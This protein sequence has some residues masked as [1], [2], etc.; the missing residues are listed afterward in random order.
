MDDK[1]LL[2]NFFGIFRNRKRATNLDFVTLC[3]QPGASGLLRRAASAYETIDS[4]APPSNPLL[5]IIA[6]Q[7][8]V[9]VPTLSFISHVGHSQE[10]LI[11]YWMNSQ[12]GGATPD[13]LLAA[14]R[15]LYGLSIVAGAVVGTAF[16]LAH[17]FYSKSLQERE[18]RTIERN[19][20][21]RL[22]ETLVGEIRANSL[23]ELVPKFGEW[24]DSAFIRSPTEKVREFAKTNAWE[25]EA[26]L[27]LHNK[28]KGNYCA[29][30]IDKARVAATFK[31]FIFELAKIPQFEEGKWPEMDVFEKDRFM[32]AEVPKKKFGIKTALGY[33]LAGLAVG[34]LAYN[35][36]AENYRDVMGFYDSL[37]H[38]SGEFRRNIGQ[39]IVDYVRSYWSPVC[40]G[41]GVLFGKGLNLARNFGA[42][43]IG[44]GHKR[45][46][47]DFENSV[48]YGR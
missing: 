38:F 3:Q 15:E 48:S 9:Q 12:P 4:R 30:Q 45:F 29:M 46:Y 16:F 37:C 28:L 34:A 2:G 14:N 23:E 44:E 11:N 6:G 24:D 19:L 43:I 47:E 21:K 35:A 20:P 7:V 5:H 17:R 13:A 25:A 18:L 27:N 32:F 36:V 22:K 39:N 42:K 40:A 26:V 8:C 31:G 33:G 41:L 10:E 1:E